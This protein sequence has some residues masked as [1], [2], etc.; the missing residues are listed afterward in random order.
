MKRLSPNII[1]N[2]LM[3]MAKFSPEVNFVVY[4][5]REVTRLELWTRVS[6]LAQALLSAGLKKDEKVIFM[7]HNSAEFVETNFAIQVAGGIPVPMNY[8]FLKREIEYQASHSDAVIFLYDS[9]FKEHVEAAIPKIT[10]VRHF[11][12]YGKTDCE[13]ALDYE[14]FIFGQPARDPAVKNDMSDIAVMIYTGGT[15]GFPKGVM[16]TYQAH[17]DMF[18]TLFSGILARSARENITKEQLEKIVESLELPGKG[19]IAAAL[20]N[21]TIKNIIGSDKNAAFLKRVLHKQFADPNLGKIL[22]GLNLNNMVPSL[23]F[24]HVASYQLL[25][26]AAMAGNVTFTLVDDVKFS[27]EKVLE[28]AVKYKTILMANVPTG[29]KKLVSFPDLHKYDLNIRFAA[30]GA[31]MCPAE[32]K[33]KIFKAFPGIIIIDLFGQTEMT[34]VTS[35]RIDASAETLKD[36]SIGNSIVEMKIVD[37]SGSE[38]AQGEPGEILYR[39]STV[40]KGYYKDEEKTQEAMLDGWFKGGDLG[41][42]DEDGELRLIDRKNECINTGGEKVFPLEVEEIIL[43]HPKVGDACIIGVPDEDWGS[44]VRAVVQL[45]NGEKSTSDEIIGF[46]RDKLAGYKIPKSVVFVDELPLSP[47]GKVLRAKIREKYGN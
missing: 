5:D 43:E 1:A 19:L 36:R 12:C 17:L 46:L 6:K 3:Y 31:G 35:F 24:F 27:P 41:F 13:K 14:E 22:Y 11:I 16:L 2:Y 26:L 44:T 7:F 9:L 15:T 28:N 8:R 38:V 39:S 42:V 34:P 45:K 33:K 21:Q 25:I 37:E 29:W 18:A 47:V 30:T 4:G 10:N 40:M 20:S 32:L 23:P